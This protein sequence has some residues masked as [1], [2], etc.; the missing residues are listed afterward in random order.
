MNSSYSAMLLDLDGTLVDSYPDA[1]QCWGEWAES[2]GVGD[3]FDLARYYGQ[4]RH[5]IVRDLLPHLSE[6]EIAA[7][8]EH[9]RLAEREYTSRVVALPGAL[10]LLSALPP[11]R[12]AIVTSNDTEV[13]KARLTSAGLPVPEVLVSADDVGHPKPHPEGFLLAAQ[14][15]GVAPSTALGVDDSPI[16]LAAARAAGMTALAVRFRHDDASLR[17]ADAI[18]DNVGDISVHL[19]NDKLVVE[20]TGGDLGHSNSPQYSRR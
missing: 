1:E 13:A 19:A 15:L 3:R 10:R 9:V 2:V 4:K 8:A 16:G 20:I 17:D 6:E 14:R 12:W 7:H 5:D 18:A 11:A